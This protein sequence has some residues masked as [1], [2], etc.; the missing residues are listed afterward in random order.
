MNEEWVTY[1][2]CFNESPTLPRI[3]SQAVGIWEGNRLFST[4][5][6][7][8]WYS[9]VESMTQYG[10]IKA[11][12][13]VGEQQ[14]L[15]EH[16]ASLLRAPQPNPSEHI[17]LQAVIR[18]VAKVTVSLVSPARETGLPDPYSDARSKA[19]RVST[20]ERFNLFLITPKDMRNTIGSISA[21][22]M[23]QQNESMPAY[24][25][26]T[27]DEE[28]DRRFDF[29]V[30]KEALGDLGSNESG[31][32]ELLSKKRDRTLARVSDEDWARERERSKALAELQ[33][34]LERYAPLFAK[35][36]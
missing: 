6:T 17:G 1:G 9:G 16:M 36:R 18:S 3:R 25:P 7:E 24:G 22:P 28:N 5:E 8:S 19:T 31:E 11:F 27:W 13:S 23:P 21:G 29:L 26:E 30:E 12:F 34:L 33:D 35:R 15:G 14:L 4:G 32:L 20:N 2:T 10:P